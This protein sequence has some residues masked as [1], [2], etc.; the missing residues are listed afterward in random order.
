LIIIKLH[1]EEL[2]RAYLNFSFSAGTI[3]SEWKEFGLIIKL[4][5]LASV[6]FLNDKM[7]ILGAGINYF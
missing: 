1:R 2:K 4:I 6:A 3:F 7:F 5:F